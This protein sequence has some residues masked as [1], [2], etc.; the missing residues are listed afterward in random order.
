MNVLTPLRMHRRL[1][2]R[3]LGR[4]MMNR[5]RFRIIVVPHLDGSTATRS[6]NSVIPDADDLHEATWLDAEWR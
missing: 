6:T 3:H 2:R 4:T 1:V 5:R